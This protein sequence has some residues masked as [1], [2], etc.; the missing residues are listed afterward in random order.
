MPYRRITALRDL[1]RITA[2]RRERVP[3]DPDPRSSHD[4]TS[5]GVLLLHWLTQ[6]RPYASLAEGSISRRPPQPSCALHSARMHVNGV[7]QRTQVQGR[8][9]YRMRIVHVSYRAY[10]IGPRIGHPASGPPSYVNDIELVVVDATTLVNTSVITLKPP[11]AGFSF[12]TWMRQL[13]CTPHPFP[14]PALPCPA[15]HDMSCW[16]MNRSWYALQW[17]HPIPHVHV[18]VMVQAARHMQTRC[19]RR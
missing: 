4:R 14:L 7:T 10:R 17:C 9:T 16:M 6:T 5:S 11:S 15:L 13:S 2:Y 3:A 19:A 12:S 18:H 8:P 1:R